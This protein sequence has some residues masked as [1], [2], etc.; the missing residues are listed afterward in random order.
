MNC[1]VCVIHC[2]STRNDLCTQALF[3]QGHNDHCLNPEQ[4]CK[5]NKSRNC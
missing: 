2:L 4:H 1:V 3:V 5:R